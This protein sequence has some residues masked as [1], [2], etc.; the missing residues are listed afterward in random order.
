VVAVD[1]WVVVWARVVV[2]VVDVDV[3]MVVLDETATAV[4]GLA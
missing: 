1:G 2:L 3:P 4:V